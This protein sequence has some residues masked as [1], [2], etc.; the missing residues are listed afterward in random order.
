VGVEVESQPQGSQPSHRDEVRQS[1]RAAVLGLLED[2]PFK[3]LT[4][5]E[6]AGAA[7]LTR[8]AF[9][10][11]FKNKVEVLAAVVEELAGDLYK[12]ADRWWSGD[13]E[14]VEL[15]MREALE[16]TARVNQRHAAVLR[17]AIE[18]TTYDAT[19]AGLYRQLTERFVTNAA[20]HIR[21][22]QAAGRARQVDPQASAEALIWMTERCGYQMIAMDGLEVSEFVDALIPVWLHALYPDGK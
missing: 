21:D 11:Y 16:G 4:I 8:T 6:I 10:F 1:M 19:F 2:R 20:E 14:N 3:D 15:A 5:D 17:A 22:E 18:V 13:D 9:Y 12:E 7:G